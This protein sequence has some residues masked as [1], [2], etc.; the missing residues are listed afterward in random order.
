MHDGMTDDYVELMIDCHSQ[1]CFTFY[2]I[3]Y[4]N[5]DGDDDNGVPWF[6]FRGWEITRDTW[7]LAILN[8]HSQREKGGG[9]GGGR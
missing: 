8:F 5:G 9:R 1:A 6:S 7:M 3:R 4:G 2:S